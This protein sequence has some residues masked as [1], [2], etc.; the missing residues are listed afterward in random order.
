MGQMTVSNEALK[1]ILFQRTGYLRF[2]N[3]FAYR[4]FKRILPFSFYNQLVTIEAR[5]GSSR[6]KSLYDDD[7]S[8]E[9]QTI[10][11]FLP[12]TCNSILDI[13]CGV[14]GIDVYLDRHYK[15]QQPDFYLLDRTKVEGS[16]FYGFE[17]TG[18][19]YNSLDVAR[20]MLT[21]NGI[22]DGRVHLLQAT[23]KNE[24]NIENPVD[25]VISLISWGF[26]YPIETYLSRVH[27]LLSDGGSLIVDIRKGTNGFSALNGVFGRVDVIQDSSKFQ[28]I[29]AVK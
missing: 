23:D 20:T 22:P 10:K 8:K 25:V 6:I 4:V 13:G 12:K 11:D 9:Y 2:Q 19:F 7:M 24:I 5:L 3:T 27:G 1:Y 14:A 15:G 28:R 26:H 17:R 16:V 21:S 29:L 18:A